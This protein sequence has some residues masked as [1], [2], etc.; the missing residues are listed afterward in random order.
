[1]KRGL[2]SLATIASIAPFVGAFGTVFCI[3]DSFLVFVGDIAGARPIVTGL[4]SQACVPTALGLLAGVTALFSYKYL[5]GRLQDFDHEM[6]ITSAELIS[7]L[8]RPAI[9]AR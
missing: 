4:L 5:T 2:N 7:C 6:E 1:M 9:S 3:V 8:A